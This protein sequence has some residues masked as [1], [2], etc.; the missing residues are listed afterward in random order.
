MNINEVFKNL[1]EI[2]KD[3]SV[4]VSW[5]D[6]DYAI[7]GIG[8]CNDFEPND[9]IK[10]LNAFDRL[11]PKLNFGENSPST[12][13]RAFEFY[14]GNEGS[15]CIYLKCRFK[16]E[17]NMDYIMWCEENKYMIEKLF[18]ADEFYIEENNNEHIIRIW[19]D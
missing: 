16:N 5:S 14:L 19:W 9:V 3:F 12:G 10:A 15:R 4:N 18:D 1:D 8:E 13:S 7:A 6:K 2:S 11:A 17:S